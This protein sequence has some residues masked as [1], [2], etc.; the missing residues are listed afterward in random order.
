MTVGKTVAQRFVEGFGGN[1]PDI[2]SDVLD[3]DVAFYGTLV[4]ELRGKNNLIDFAAQFQQAMPGLRIVLHD[5]FYS[6]DGTRGNMRI[7]LHFHNTGEFMGHQPTGKQG[8]SVESFSMV[9]KDDKI[10]ELI[11][12]GNTFALGAIELIDFK[13]DYP[14]ETPDP[15]K[16]IFVASEN[17]IK[18]LP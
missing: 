15:H 17:E 5:E 8:V 10:T 4:W 9:I 16:A 12:S 3:D 11:Q 1:N 6:A 14:T 13:M 7:H 2:L 18:V